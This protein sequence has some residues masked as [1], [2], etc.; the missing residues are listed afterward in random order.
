VNYGGKFDAAL[1]PAGK[2][3]P[4]YLQLDTPP[5]HAPSDAI[6]VPDAHFLFNADFKRTGLDLVLSGDG[7]ELVLHDYFKG[8]K[9]AALASPDGAHLSGDIVNALTGA[10]QI[11]QAGADPT[12]GK[13]IGHVTKLQGTATAIRNGVSIILHQGDNV[14]KGDVV[15]SGS[16]S[17]LGLTF[18][19]GTV[20]GLSS[21][22]RMVLN[23]MVYDPNGSNNSS[24]LS[25]VA[26][27]I[28]FVA[29]ETAKHGDMKVDTPVATMGIRG[30]AVLVEIDFTVPGQNTTPDA[31]FQVL[32][33]PDGTTG[34]YVLFDKV[35]LQ[36]IAVV[37]QAGHQIHISNGV[38]TQTDTGLPPEI[39]KLITD[40]FS[41]KFTDNSSNPKSSTHFT[42]FGVLETE[43]L[44]FA[45]GVT[46]T[47]TYLTANNVN[48][49]APAAS[50]AVLDPLHHIPGPPKVAVLDG[51]GNPATHFSLI[52][53]LDQTGDAADSDSVAIK[54]NFADVNAGDHPTVSVNFKSFVYQD[55][56]HGDV[57]GSLSALQL[58]DIA[59]AEVAISVVPNPNNKN[60]GSASLT[61]SVPDSAFDFLAAGETLTLTYI[62]RVD[63][64]FAPNNEYTE[65]PVTITITGTNDSPVI[66]TSAQT[67]AFSGGTSVSGGD[68][69]SDDAT[70][71]SL[72]FTDVDLTDTHTVS[73]KL[74]GAVLENGGTIPPAP[75][76][77]FE[78][79]FSASLAGDST[80]TGHGTVDWKLGDLPVYVA[81]FIP[82]GQTLTLT[83]TVTVTDSQGV[84]TQ[85]AV[86]VTITGTDNPAVVW[87]ATA[88]DDSSGSLWRVG[89]NWETGVAPTADDDVIVIT[90]QL[91]GVTPAFP[92]RIDQAAVAKTVT[93]NDFGGGAR[94]EIDNFSTLTIGGALTVLAD[95][96]VYNFKGATISVGGQA[97]FLDQSVLGNSGTLKLLAGGDFGS[98]V[99]VTN[100]GTIELVAGTMNVS[101]DIVNAVGNHSGLVKIDIGGTLV[102]DNGSIAGG[103]LV[104]AG[105]IHIETDAATTFDHV[106]VDNGGGV[107]IVDEEGTQP[108]PSKLVLDVR[109]VISGG[110]MT[111]G[112]VGTLEIAGF[113]A[114]LS[115]VH[116][117]NSGIF[118]VDHHGFLDL[119]GTDVTGDGTFHVY[120]TVEASG[121][122]SLGGAVI[123]DG[124]I[125]VTSGILEVAGA[126]SGTGTIVVD[127]GAEVKLDGA[128]A[129]TIDFKGRG[130]ELVLDTASFGGK[131]QGLDI[132]DKLDLASIKFADDP[133]ATYDK[134]SGVLTVSDGHGDTVKLTLT[135]LDYSHLNF[136]VSD[137]GHGGTL[138]TVK[139]NHAPT[140]LG[141]TDPSLQT[142]ILSKS[143]TVLPAGVTTNTAG[144]A[145]ETFDQAAAG[146]PSNNGHGF[147]NFY[148][149]TLH[150]WFSASGDAGVVHGSS[151]GSAAPYV[152]DGQQ[153]STNYLSIG[154]H[155]SETLTFDSLQNSFGLYWGSADSFNSISFYDGNKLVASYSGNNISPLLAN[156]GQGSFSSNGYAEFLN[157]APFDKVVLTSS[158]AA[159][160]LDNVSAGYIPDTHS[161]LA[162]PVSGTLTVSDKDVGDTLTASV[163]GDAVIKYNGSSKLPSNVDAG[164]LIDSGAITFDSVTSDG[165]ADVLHWT[166]NP[167]NANFDFLEPGDTLTI[168][169]TAQVSDGHGS[170]GAQPLTITIAGNGASTVNGTAQNDV[171]TNIGS[172]VTVFG[173][174]GSDTFV[175]NAH[176]GSATIGDFDVNKDT[177]EIDHSLFESVSA[178][179][180][181]AHSANLGHDTVITSGANDTITLKGVTL[182][183]LQQ[184]QNDFHII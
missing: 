17:T 120:G 30:T 33:E 109:T 156:G 95:A 28:S 34:S 79:A 166:Y 10:V 93:M 15:Q 143:P 19:D 135:D 168:T 62:V 177:I 64:N 136:A 21:N 158:Q 176:L 77:L 179:M 32:V 16:D 184:H 180:A 92:V 90:D 3:A 97:E 182:A 18:I 147:G 73:A 117:D 59:A 181:N 111:V 110:K 125:E 26:G 78:Q 114:T 24:L 124:I 89:A 52:E 115:G 148:S 22:A 47:L 11:S 88:G 61:Y 66:T 76:A 151:S 102:L 36:P 5:A 74:T 43:G 6:V 116:V 155:A 46:A 140:I 49:G 60:S 144:M 107:I 141:E 152:G 25:L 69:I 75:L 128:N 58:Q 164:A 104:N 137:D 85:Q 139:A 38:V 23:E 14:E 86:T 108:V 134:K 35:T 1:F 81:D 13:V 167:A 160:E 170:V 126:I 50:D 37:N 48:Q 7:R 113:G 9:H 45:S 29:G 99:H 12:V 72:A 162:D 44:K 65:V 70:S 27:T 132:S 127:S 138:I 145:T 80:G 68:L 153:D 53:R 112:L 131:I 105:T 63:N 173:H 54:V 142:I 121:F 159:F 149:E 130:G 67:I 94:P 178:I 55:A 51:S 172:G 71:G 20:F 87:I 119:I 122:S 171:F 84:A 31:K 98:D 96:R 123:N 101:T 83:Y 42:D 4:G 56:A 41:L 163:T 161:K 133:T 169:Y 129:Q 8:E 118:T 165:K 39:Q 154:A 2:Q 57:T 40:V 150:A 100:T 146:S 82:Y 91:H 174:G 175:F 157:L 106:D 183:Q 103:H